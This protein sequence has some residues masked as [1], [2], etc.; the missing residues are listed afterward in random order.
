MKGFSAHLIGDARRAGADMSTGFRQ[1]VFAAL[2]GRETQRRRE[3]AHHWIARCGCCSPGGYRRPIGLVGG[4]RLLTCD[5]RT[6]RFLFELCG[7]ERPVSWPVGNGETQTLGP[8]VPGTAPRGLRDV[9]V[10]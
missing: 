10:E 2:S 4:S 8:W 7:Y 6:K 5:P 3:R 9:E 1:L